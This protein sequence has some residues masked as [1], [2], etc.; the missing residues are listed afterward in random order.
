[1]LIQVKKSGYTGSLYVIF[2]I[3]NKQSFNT[4]YKMEQKKNITQFCRQLFMS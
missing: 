2:I 3:P 4:S 1:M